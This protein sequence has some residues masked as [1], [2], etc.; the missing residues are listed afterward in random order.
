MGNPYLLTLGS[1]LNPA[2]PT[3]RHGITESVLPAG[4]EPTQLV[5]H[6][7]ALPT[8]LKEHVA[9]HDFSASIRFSY[10]TNKFSLRLPATSFRT[11]NPHGNIHGSF[12]AGVASKCVHHS[13]LP[14]THRIRSACAYFHH[15][16]ALQL[17]CVL[18]PGYDPGASTVS[19]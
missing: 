3:S 13:S 18:A 7:S 17:A 8:M 12:G 6:T 10:A 2:F 16:P 15:Y 19:E 11:Y 9:D 5:L 1:T 4:I 14:I